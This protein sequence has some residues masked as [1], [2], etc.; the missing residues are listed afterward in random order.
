MTDVLVVA[1]LLEGGMRRSTL[2]A[3]TFAKQVAEGTGGSFDILAVGEGSENAASQL[4]SYGARKIL[5]AEIEGGYVAEKYAPTVAEVSKSGDYGVVVA[6][7]TTATVTL[8]VT[9]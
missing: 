7:A 4:S 3:V 2:S 6:T 9:T 1:E 8:P 5:T